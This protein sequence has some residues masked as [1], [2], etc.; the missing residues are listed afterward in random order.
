MVE[1]VMIVIMS[2]DTCWKGEFGLGSDRR[3]FYEG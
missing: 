3:G 2:V 1:A